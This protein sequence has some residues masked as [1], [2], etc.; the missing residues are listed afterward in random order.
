[1][2]GRD[3]TGKIE[4]PQDLLSS[5]LPAGKLIKGEVER[6]TALQA[7]SDRY[8]IS[9]DSASEER[10]RLGTLRDVFCCGSLYLATNRHLRQGASLLGREV[11]D[12]LTLYEEAL[13]RVFQQGVEQLSR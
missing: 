10:A 9:P 13:D 7:L 6:L 11:G 8:F 5:R 4:P 2:L 12:F 3:R 1:M